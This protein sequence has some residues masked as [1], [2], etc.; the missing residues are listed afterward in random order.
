MSECLNDLYEV[1]LTNDK[2]VLLQKS[3]ELANVAVKTSS[4]ITDR[5]SIRNIVMQGTVW[6]GL[7]CTST[8]DKLCKLILQDEQVLYKFRGTVSVPPLEMVDDVITAVKC[9]STSRALNA[10]VN[11]FMEQKRLQLNVSKCGKIHIGNKSSR[12]ICPDHKVHTEIMKCSEQEKYLGYI[13]S[14]KCNSKETIK[15]RRVRGNAILSEMGAI[16]RD[17]PLVKWRTQIGLT[18]RQAWFLNGSVFNSEV[19]SGFIDNDLDD[20]EVIDHSIIRLITGAQAKV[21]VEMLYLE[22]ALLPVKSGISVSTALYSYCIR[23]DK[24]C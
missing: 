21:P 7:M 4:G 11:A 1:G 14:N 19:W 5:F 3:N 20:L 15:D 24:S 23:L 17:I 18:L 2:L 8:M 12:K 22:T 16:L 13:D 9:G 10:S 6:S